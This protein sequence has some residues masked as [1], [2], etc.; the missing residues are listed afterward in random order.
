MVDVG[1]S[2]MGLGKGLFC[3]K[4]RRCPH[5]GCKLEWNAE[6]GNYECPCHGSRF[7][8]NGELL[9]NPAQV[10]LGEKE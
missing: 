1:E 6:E 7:G 10:D 5:M 2:V 3:K 4:E 8:G 9:D